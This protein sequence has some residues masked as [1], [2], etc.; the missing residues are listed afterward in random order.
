MVIM[1]DI[2]RIFRK[3]YEKWLRKRRSRAIERFRKRFEEAH[4]DGA[5]YMQLLESLQ[6]CEDAFMLRGSLCATGFMSAAGLSTAYRE[7]EDKQI[8]AIGEK[9]PDLKI[10]VF[11]HHSADESVDH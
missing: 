2:L 10:L 4:P 11:H 3:G 1:N 8:K 7:W 9:H 6:G 5:R